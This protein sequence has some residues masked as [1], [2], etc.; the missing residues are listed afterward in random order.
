MVE[1]FIEKFQVPDEALP[2]LDSIFRCEEM[3]LV[4][5]LPNLSFNLE[6]AALALQNASGRIW[7]TAEVN[8]FLHTT[9]NRGIINLNDDTYTS[10]HI[11]NF[12]TRLDVFVVSEPEIYLAFPQPIRKKIDRWYFNAYLENLD[13]T[14]RPSADRV[15][16]LE[17]TFELI[18]SEKR[19]PWLSYCDCRILAGNC[20]KPTHT[21]ISF[22]SGLNSM[23]H[24]GWSQP[25]TKDELKKVVRKANRKGLMQTAH[26]NGICN[27]CGDCCYLFRA[28][29]VRSRGLV[30]PATDHIAA[31]DAESCIDCGACVRRC[32]FNAFTADGDSIQFHEELCRGCGLC[33][34]ICP[35]DAIEMQ[36]RS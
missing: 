5:N 9:Y 3:E 22:F 18:D 29:Q 26:T 31:Y 10:F 8:D 6:D 7:K 27:C 34:E 1:T 2:V 20:K 24:R 13:D 30:W 25:V 12:Y 36:V 15:L 33:A 11:N 28:Q 32:H 16:T 19:T 4:E 35:A 17:Q 23:A 21:C 14:D